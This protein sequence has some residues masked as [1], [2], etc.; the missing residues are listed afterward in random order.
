M[1][2]SRSRSTAPSRAPSRG[3]GRWWNGRP[4]RHAEAREQQVAR[5]T[6]VAGA[7]ELVLVALHEDEADP[8]RHA[9]AL[10]AVGAGLSA[11]DDGGGAL[12]QLA[13]RLDGEPGRDAVEL[14]R[15]RR[16]S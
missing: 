7:D 6:G 4:L 14:L 2:C 8:G 10:E 1:R 3:R 12:S 9:L 11:A 5:A 15:R 13:A 16:E